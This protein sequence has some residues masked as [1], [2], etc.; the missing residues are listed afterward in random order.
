VCGP[1]ATCSSPARG[2]RAHVLEANPRAS[3]TV[4]FVSE[5]DRGAAGQGRPARIM[6]GRHH[7]GPAGRGHAS[8]PTGRRR[9]EQPPD[10]GPD[11]GRRRPVP[12]PFHQR[13][14]HPEGPGPSTAC[15][16]RR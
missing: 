9:G 4:P 7:R 12:C 2:T 1:A 13:F 6:L 14:R 11:R 3:R 16:D 15:S 5:G 10:R 8:W